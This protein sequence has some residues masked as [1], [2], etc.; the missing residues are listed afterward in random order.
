MRRKRAAVLCASLMA[1][2]LITGGCGN[3]ASGTD[4]TQEV[5]TTQTA[6]TAQTDNGSA[7]GTISL[8]VWGAEEDAELLKQITDSFA[9]EYASQAT[10]DI[11]IAAESESDCKDALLGDVLNA[12]DVFTF[13]DDQLRALVAS[14][15]LEPIENSDKVASASVDGAADAASVND[16]LYAYPLTADNGYFLYYNKEYFSDTDVQTLDQ[17]L[18]VAAANGKK[19]AMDWSSGWYL[20]SFFGNTGMELGLNDDGISNYCNWNSQDGSI[21][22]VDVA[23]SMLSIAANPGFLNTDDQGMMEGIQNGSVIAGV[24]G[25]WSANGIEQ[26]WGDNYAAI[27]LPTYTCAGQQVQMASFKGYKL[28]G[29]NAYSKNA[30][31]ASKLAEWIS[32]EQNQTL[33]FEMNGQGPSNTKAA[34]S[35]EV[36]QAPAIQAVITQ[37]EFGK[38][39]SVGNT[40]WDACTKFGNIMAKGNKDNVKLQKLMD[41]LVEEITKSVAG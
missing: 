39:Q 40:Y 26:A 5:E 7:D 20:Y 6:E 30:A 18:S 21:K 16:Q 25:V 38:L 27:K 35:D 1:A 29:A 33:R 10:F 3:G 36:K 15:V 14:G 13:A 9:K 22:G 17:M 24:S 31:W 2:S 19:V 12:P 32:N 34:D 8:T 11:T 23:Q 28:V 41:T 4:G 37:S